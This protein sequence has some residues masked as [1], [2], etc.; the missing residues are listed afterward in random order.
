MYI[1]SFCSVFIFICE[2]H[3]LHIL[4]AMIIIGKVNIFFCILDDFYNISTLS[5]KKYLNSKILY[6]L[7]YE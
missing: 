4:Y 1:I 2:F 6:R 7:K 3:N 5:D